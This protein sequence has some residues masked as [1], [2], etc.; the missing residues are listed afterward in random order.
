MSK[1]NELMNSTNNVNAN[2]NNQDK[3]ELLNLRPLP[4]DIQKMSESETAC[5]YCGI[6]YLLLHKYEKM[7]SHVKE[8]DLKFTELQKYIQER[9]GM[10]SRLETLLKLQKES[11]LQVSNLETQLE[12]LKKQV[13]WDR[14]DLSLFRQ[15]NHELTVQLVSS[16]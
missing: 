16:F 15:K 8:I 3:L 9:P 4:D 7:E 11:S 12:S 5:Q 6:S 1:T 14:S 13:E 2:N 10:L